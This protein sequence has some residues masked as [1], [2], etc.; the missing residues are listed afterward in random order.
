MKAESIIKQELSAGRKT[1]KQLVDACAEKKVKRS[2][3]FY[4]LKKMRKNGTVRKVEREYELIKLEEADQRDIDFLM[5]KISD[6]NQ[7][8]RKAAIEDFA[9]LCRERG[10]T[11]YQQV[12]PFIKN[13]LKSPPYPELRSA[14]LRFLR[15]ITVNS[16]RKE[17]SARAEALEQLAKFKEILE[18]LVLNEKLDQSLR[19]DATIVL[20]VLLND[21]EIPSLIKLLEHIIRET[22]EKPEGVG[23]PFQVV[24]LYLWQT[25]LKRTRFLATWDEIRKWLYNLLEYENR[26]VREMSL[27]LLDE[28]RMKEY[29]FEL[30]PV[31]TTSGHAENIS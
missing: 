24:G 26:R 31:S 5:E 4:H 10:I 11:N 9:A 30:W 15:F 22:A 20:D 21:N 2:T 13:L 17:A 1:A 23:Q 8:A 28:L 3:V 25:I 27:R 16:K 14:A 6:R 7:L 18:I 12:L 29:G 19:Y